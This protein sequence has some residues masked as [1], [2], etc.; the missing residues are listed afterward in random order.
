MV[1]LASIIVALIGTNGASVMQQSGYTTNMSKCRIKKDNKKLK[2]TSLTHFYI[3]CLSL[4]VHHWIY[5]RPSLL[6]PSTFITS[7]TWPCALCHSEALLPVPL[8]ATQTQ[9]HTHTLHR[10]LSSLCP[11]STC[12]SVSYCTLKLCT[13]WIATNLAHTHTHTPVSIQVVNGQGKLWDTYIRLH[14]KMFNSCKN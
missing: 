9:A 3:C 1:S 13:I 5:S 12:L 10:F 7:I 8:H 14:K 6:S 4:L 11:S 2:H